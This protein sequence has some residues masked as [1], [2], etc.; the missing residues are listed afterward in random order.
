M[1]YFICNFLFQCICVIE[2]LFLSDLNIRD[3]EKYLIKDLLFYFRSSSN[4]RLY[5]LEFNFN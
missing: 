4:R 1:E 2:F 3:T 5:L